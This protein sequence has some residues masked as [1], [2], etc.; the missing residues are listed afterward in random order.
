VS[1]HDQDGDC[2]ANLQVHHNYPAQVGVDLARFLL[3]LKC[4]PLTLS[5]N[6]QPSRCPRSRVSREWIKGAGPVAMR[7]LTEELIQ[8][9]NKV[10]LGHSSDPTDYDPA[11]S[12]AF[13]VV[14][15]NWDL[16]IGEA[17]GSQ[18]TPADF[19]YTLGIPVSLKRKLSP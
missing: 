19:L 11:P 17:E 6:E 16:T 1:F 13:D 7:Y 18:E 15:S 9:G 4:S 3:T 14:V 2:Y 5:P 12:H 10:F 8:M